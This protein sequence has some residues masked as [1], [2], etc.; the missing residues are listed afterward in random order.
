MNYTKEDNKKIPQ[1]RWGI[2]VV[3]LDV[4]VRIIKKKKRIS[5]LAPILNIPV[6]QTGHLPFNAGFPFL[7]VTFSGFS[8][9][10]L[11]LHFT[12]YIELVAIYFFTPLRHL[13]QITCDGCACE[14]YR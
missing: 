3:F 2:F 5:Y 9:S 12:Q 13:M 10:L 7:R 8:T 6:L 1:I 11:A 4:L 14:R